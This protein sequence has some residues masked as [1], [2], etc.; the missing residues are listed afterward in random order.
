VARDVVGHGGMHSRVA[1]DPLLEGAAAGFEL[2]LDESNENSRWRGECR[3][4]GKDLLERDEA[5]VDCDDIGGRGKR[6]GGKRANIALYSRLPFVQVDDHACPDDAYGETRSGHIIAT[7]TLKDGTRFSV[8]TTHLDWPAPKMA[9][10]AEQFET[11]RE[12]IAKID[13]PLILAGD[14]NSTSWSYALRDFTAAA[15]LTRQDHNIF[16]FPMRFYIAGWRD[17]WPPFLPLDHVMTRGPV[18]VHGLHAGP[19][20][21][22]DHLPLIFTFSVGSGP[23]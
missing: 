17:T 13:T 11:L 4:S 18:A 22:S 1:H 2:R 14:F 8:M 3:R 6:R 15:G 23:A 21:G 9:R 7:F 10:Q 20:T 5:H 12:A 19:A 16:T